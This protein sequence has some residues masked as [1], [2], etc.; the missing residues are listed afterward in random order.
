[1]TL[2][3]RNQLLSIIL[4][5]IIIALGYY[6]YHSIVD[7]YQK[8]IEDRQMTERVRHNMMNIRDA[9]MQYENRNGNF[10]PTDGGLDSLVEF[11]KTDSLMVTTGDSLF[12]PMP[13]DTYSPDSL[14]ISPR[15][16]HNKFEYT[17]NDTLNPQI[18]LLQDP[19]SEDRIGD[20]EK[21]TLLNG[22][23]WR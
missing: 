12:K 14:V 20:L 3:Q 22:A 2:A 10:P 8:V 4:G 13:P 17:L 16:P 21:T 11:L 6:L 5:I 18:Y 1:M 7:P 23:S 15:P 9:L 19:D